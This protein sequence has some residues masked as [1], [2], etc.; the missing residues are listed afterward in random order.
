MIY[1]IMQVDEKTGTDQSADS[2]PPRNA[3][4]AEVTMCR[5]KKKGR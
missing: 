1:E 4:I 5:Y 3:H 2:L